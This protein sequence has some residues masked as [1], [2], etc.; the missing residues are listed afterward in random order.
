MVA[1]QS[2]LIGEISDIYKAIECQVR[3]LELMPEGL[4]EKPG[5]LANL[6][7]AYACRF[8]RL[9]DLSDIERVIECHN[10]L[11]ELTSEG[12]G[13]MYIC[14]SLLGDSYGARFRRL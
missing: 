2:P 11:V 9:D 3:G 5:S 6:G 1:K 13:K 7:N 8:E 12:Y 14:L 10:Q 4:P